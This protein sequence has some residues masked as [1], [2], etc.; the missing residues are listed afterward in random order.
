LRDRAAPA[1]PGRPGTGLPLPARKPVPTRAMFV[2]MRPV[3]AA[4]LLA[5]L[6]TGCPRKAEKP[7]ASL[8]D[9]IISEHDFQR[10]L[11]SAYLADEI[12]LMR[13]DPSRRQAALDEYLDSLAIAA[14]ARKLGID[15]EERFKKA[16]ELLDL[17]I[18]AHLLTERYRSRLVQATQV[19]PDEVKRFYQEHKGEYTVHPSFSAHHLL[20][21]VQGNPAFPDKGLSDAQ[22]RA[23]ASEAQHRLR[24]GVSWDTVA[25]R[26]SD[27]VATNQRGGLIRDG[28]FGL[29]PPE[30]ERAVRTQDLGKPGE[31]VKSAFGY[32]V[33]QVESR[34]LEETPEP[35]AKVESLLSERLNLARAAEARKLLIEPMA[36]EVGLRLTEAA[37]PDAVLLDASAVPANEVLAVVAGKKILESD[38]RWFLKDALIPQQRMTAYSRPGARKNMLDSFLDMLVLEAKARKQGMHK[39]PEFVRQRFVMRQGLLLE[40]LQERD[41]AGPFCQCQETPEARQASQKRYFA[42]VRAEMHLRILDHSD[43]NS[44]PN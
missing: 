28:Q 10:Y 41:N 14:K 34:V 44:L 35:F 22:A 33:L 21:Y 18:L 17:K 7:I 3:I 30:V 36:E 11:A 37:K 39:T 5:G 40:F 25:R 38:F 31:V 2:P 23:K 15:Q 16:V 1:S 9:E 32:H 27:D 43:P 4:L 13:S 24:A 26:Y 20:V 12:A 6:A 8:G 19:S 42:S 29:F